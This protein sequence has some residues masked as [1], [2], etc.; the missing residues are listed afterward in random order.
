MFR[1]RSLGG[2]VVTGEKWSE[3]VFRYILTHPGMKMQVILRN[4][5][6]PKVKSLT[7]NVGFYTVLNPRGGRGGTPPP[8]VIKCSP[9][10]F[11]IRDF[12]FSIVK[13][14]K[15]NS[16]PPELYKSHLDPHKSLTEKS[17]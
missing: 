6:T 12:A 17:V 4:H 2:S 16:H 13:E 5:R 14:K 1:S 3:R 8:G 9:G 11:E 10:R 15:C 7:L